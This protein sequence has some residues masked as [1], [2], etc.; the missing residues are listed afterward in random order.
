M[1]DYT[2]IY[3]EFFQRGSHTNSVTRYKYISCEPKD[4]VKTVEQEI[5]WSSVWL[6]F[7]GKCQPVNEVPK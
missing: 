5:G 4:F 6:T 7:E 3:A 1:K 2:I